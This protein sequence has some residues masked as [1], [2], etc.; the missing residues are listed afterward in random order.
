[1]ASLQRPPPITMEVIMHRP[2]LLLLALF[3]CAVLNVS[4]IHAS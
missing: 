2:V 3:L 1:M 4:E